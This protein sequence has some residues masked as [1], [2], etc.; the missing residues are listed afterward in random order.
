M[1]YSTLA[2]TFLALIPAI[3]LMIY[4]Y[5]MDKVE[6]EPKGLLTGLFFL[7]VLS[8][9]PAVL[10]E[11]FAESCLNAVFF[12]VFTNGSPQYF[13]S[14]GSMFL[15]QFIN[16][17]ICVALIEEFFK[18]LFTF[19]VTRNNKN[20]NCMFDGVV[21]SV[22]VSLGFAAAEN[23]LYVYENGFGNAVLRMLTAVP[24]HCFFGVIMGYFYGRWFLNRGAGRLERRLRDARVIPQGPTAFNTG[25]LL[26]LS[27]FVPALA[28]GFYDF[29]ATMDE[30]IFT[31]A[32]FAFLIFLYIWFF[33]SVRGMSRRDTDG[34]FVSMEMVL[35][36]Y[37]GSLGYV[38]ALP[39]YQKYFV[40][41]FARMSAQDAYGQPYNSGPMPPDMM[42]MPN[43]Q[44][45]PF[46]QP[47]N[48][49]PYGQPTQ[50]QPPVDNYPYG[51]PVQGQDPSSSY[52]PDENNKR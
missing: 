47:I 2:L 11:L 38:S 45:S 3:A 41:Y 34:C 35:N 18:W 42:N 33:R 27:I 21:Y 15:Y 30:W 10:A 14:S 39:E 20:F 46:A 8:V 25:G 26:A 19:L 22:F 4:I 31:V 32:F 29:C 51:Q 6:K 37:P 17:F 49:Q 44:N 13:S 12:G 5:K 28:H 7:G 16:N 48:S 52:F 9:I 43:V 36:R 50:G 23:L 40:D 1:S 24:A